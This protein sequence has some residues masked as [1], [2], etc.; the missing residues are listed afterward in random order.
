[1]PAQQG[2]WLNDGERLLP[3]SN[4]PSSE[5]KEDAIRLRACGA[6]HLPLEDDHLLS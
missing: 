3:G 1:M 2:F 4:S 6:F 5:H